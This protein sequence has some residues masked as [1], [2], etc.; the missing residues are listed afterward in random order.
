MCIVPHGY[1][2]NI[3]KLATNAGSTGATILMGRGIA[4]NSILQALALGDSSKDVVYILMSDDSKNKIISN[5]QNENSTKKKGFG[6]LFTVS[7]THL[8][9][10]GIVSKGEKNMTSNTTHTLITVIANKGYADDIMA[11]ARKAGAGGGTVIHARGTAMQNDP[12]FFGMEIVPEKDMLLVAVESAKASVVLEA[13]H[14][15]PCL[16]KPGSG[17]VF[18]SPASDFIVL[19]KNA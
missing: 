13:I 5:I 10:N 18:C 6:V 1:G 19:G 16:E 2:E 9:K 7:A 8:V 3:S 17:I 15:L 4:S 11:A 14:T 12:K